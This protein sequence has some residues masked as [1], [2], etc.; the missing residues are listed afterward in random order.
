MPV[1]RY[2]I[3][4]GGDLWDVTRFPERPDTHHD[5]QQDPTTAPPF[6][7]IEFRCAGRVLRTPLSAGSLP[8]REEFA[9]MSPSQFIGLLDR[10]RPVEE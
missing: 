4:I 1:R 10:A 3:K 2:G 9:K 8:S 5:S 7:G 6:V